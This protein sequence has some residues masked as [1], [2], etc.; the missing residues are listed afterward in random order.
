MDLT[1]EQW[2][3]IEPHIPKVPSRA[4]GRGRPRRAE[5][6]VVNG[7]MWIMRTGAQWKEIPQPKYPSGS[8]CHSR[9]Q[10]WVRLGVI[11]RILSTLAEDLRERGKLDL[12]ECFIDGTFVSAKKGAN[13]WA[14]PSA[15]KVAR[16]WQLQTALAFLSPFT[17]RLLRPMKSPSLNPQLQT[18][19]SRMN[20]NGSSE[21]KPTTATD[22]MPFLPNA[23]VS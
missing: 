15:A 1:D 2:K 18:V 11:E 22:R 12:S 13:P 4:D 9:F 21:T 14:R 10:T 5:R 19:L 8:T 17:Y 6:V 16:S 23:A 3:E 20:P 7:I